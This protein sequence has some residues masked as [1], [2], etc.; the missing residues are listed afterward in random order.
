M[1]SKY[2][3]YRQDKRIVSLFSYLVLVISVLISPALTLILL[4]VWFN[5]VNKI[6]SILITGL[7]FA[8]CAFYFEP[9]SSMD[10][11]S[12]YRLASNGTDLKEY[13]VDSSGN[14]SKADYF[15]I[16]LFVIIKTLSLNSHFIAAFSAFIY[17]SGLSLLAFVWADLLKRPNYAT[18]IVISL[19]LSEY[20]LGFTGIRYDNACVLFILAFTY[21][22]KNDKKISVLFLIISCFFHFSILPLALLI[23]ISVYCKPK[24]ILK[25][26]WI[27]I[28][29]GFFII[30][31]LKYISPILQNLGTIGYALAGSI[32]SYAFSEEDSVLYAGS[33][34]W[35]IQRLLAFFFSTFIILKKIH[36]NNE[37]KN[38]NP[39]LNN[40]MHLLV[41]YTIFSFGIPQ[42]FMR[43]LLIF[44]YIS[45]FFAFKIIISNT[46]YNHLAIFYITLYL[47]LGIAAN[48][49]GKEIFQLLN[50]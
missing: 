20:L 19:I 18:I 4:P 34:L 37:L 40:F 28:F 35:P 36:I 44:S 9:E 41:A 23:A 50:Y 12:Y 49:S 2:I 42:L 27:L 22:I 30:P 10:L 17:F 39:Y 16:I 3:T 33:R 43:T 24:I 25:I 46:K 45:V 26:F 1:D 15:I 8:F 21:L 14:F 11:A 7:I 31:L 6:I 29:S 13:Y 48:I 32:E 5:N 47:I 38:N